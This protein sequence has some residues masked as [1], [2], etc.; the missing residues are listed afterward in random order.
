MKKLVAVFVLILG[1]LVSGALANSRDPM[2]GKHDF[3]DTRVLHIWSGG[4]WKLPRFQGHFRIIVTE[5]YLNNTGNRMFVEWVDTSDLD[6]EYPTLAAGHAVVELNESPF[7]E[8]EL[9]TCINP[10]RC[11]NFKVLARNRKTGE[12]AEFEILLRA[13]GELSTLK[14]PNSR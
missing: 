11:N 14:L 1:T 3:V 5:D 2:A 7:D 8:F 9:P 6:G 13:P 10:P 12:R 4:Q